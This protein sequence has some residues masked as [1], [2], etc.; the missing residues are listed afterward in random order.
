M[1]NSLTREFARVHKD[2]M[3]KQAKF[4]RA[5]EQRQLD[6]GAQR[7][8]GGMLPPAAAAALN[9]LMRAGYA[10][11]RARCIARALAEAVA[12]SMRRGRRRV[13]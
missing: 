12:Y 4:S 6:A 3:Q 13:A 5:Y 10:P 1:T 7:M 9:A 8:P 2:A 11:S